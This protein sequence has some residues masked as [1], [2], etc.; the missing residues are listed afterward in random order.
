MHMADQ[1]RVLD[2]DQLSARNSDVRPLTYFELLAE[3]FNDPLITFTMESLP[4]LH[5]NFAKL[6]GINFEDMP[7][8]TTAEQMKRKVFQ[9]VV[10]L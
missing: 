5:Q 2:K 6:I 7:E 4:E 10:Q 1:F 8:K 3:K 9:A